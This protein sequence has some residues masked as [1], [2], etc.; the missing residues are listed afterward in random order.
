M[1]RTDDL[2]EE[3]IV[4][5]PARFARSR[6]HNSDPGLGSD[7]FSAVTHDD[8]PLSISIS[9][10]PCIPGTMLGLYLPRRP[11]TNAWS[12]VIPVFTAANL[13]LSL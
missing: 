3:E 6:D 1:L 8:V 9:V 7:C 4:A 10:P 5:P 12:F 11:L 2:A 13:H